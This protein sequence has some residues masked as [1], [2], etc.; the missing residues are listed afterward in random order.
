MRAKG[1]TKEAKM[2]QKSQ[3]VKVYH[4]I[5]IKKRD[6]DQIN[7]INASESF[8][9]VYVFSLITILKYGLQTANLF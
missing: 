7:L 2:S 1:I 6:Q 9:F 3:K 5:S 8:V 4:E